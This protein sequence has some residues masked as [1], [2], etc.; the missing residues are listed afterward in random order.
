MLDAGRITVATGEIK[1]LENFHFV[2]TS[3]LG[4]AEAMWI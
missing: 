2:F 4:A 3:N 1:S